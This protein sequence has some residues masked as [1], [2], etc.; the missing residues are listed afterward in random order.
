MYSP[1]YE[2]L[3]KILRKRTVEETEVMLRNK[4]IF[5]FF[6]L[7]AHAVET[8]GALLDGKPY[9]SREQTMF[10][11]NLALRKLYGI[12]YARHNVNNYFY[13]KFRCD[14]V[15][16]L[17]PSK[18]LYL[19]SADETDKNLHLTFADNR[20]VLVA[21]KMQQDT[22]NALERLFSHL[23]KDP[24]LMKKAEKSIISTSEF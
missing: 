14:L 4:L 5:P 8:F 19:T 7:T 2:E 11:F 3:K 21:E 23:E 22:R 10:R 15:H 17:L 6:V 18:H 24:S 16:L 20:L 13:Q 12:E 9:R 1:E